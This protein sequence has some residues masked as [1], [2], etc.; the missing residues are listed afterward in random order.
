MRQF[1]PST[2]SLA[3][4]LAGQEPAEAPAPAPEPAEAPKP[5]APVQAPTTDASHAPA[6]KGDKH[7]GR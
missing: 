6:R 4:R 1:D 7:H 2:D 5:A 3:A